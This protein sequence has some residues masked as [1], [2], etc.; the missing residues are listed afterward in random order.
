VR[1]KVAA[2]LDREILYVEDNLD[3]GELVRAVLDTLGYATTVVTNV[4]EAK[5]II[6]TSQHFLLYLIDVRLPDGSGI[7]LCR[8]I[9]QSDSSTPIAVYSA[10]SSY[11]ADAFSAGAQA[12]VPKSG[13]IE[14]LESTV[15]RLAGNNS[16]VTP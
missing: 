13:D 14:L 9:R 5:Q 11:M 3:T 6:G 7:D 10:N 12:F 2:L 1:D 16:I 15:L 4:S 8:W